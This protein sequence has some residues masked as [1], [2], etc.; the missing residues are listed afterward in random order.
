MREGKIVLVTG[1]T[2]KVGQ[3]FISRFM[4]DSAWA[5][6]KIRA[7]CHN[8]LL[9]PDERLEV[10]QGSMAEREDVARAVS[11]VTYVVHLATC[12]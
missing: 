10:V 11:G 2:G 9:E 8:R 12:L 1:A 5:G 6:A 4:A 3:N 7:L